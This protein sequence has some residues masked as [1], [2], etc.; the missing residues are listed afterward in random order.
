MQIG[1]TGVTLRGRVTA[2]QGGGA[3]V[4][5]LWHEGCSRQSMRLRTTTTGLA[6]AL[7]L[8]VLP[9]PRVHAAADEQWRSDAALGARMR[10]L[11]DAQAT[12]TRFYVVSALGDMPDTAFVRAR[13]FR[14]PVDFEPA[15]GPYY[16]EQ[17]AQDFSDALGLHLK[18]LVALLR[19]TKEGDAQTGAALKIRWRRD[20]EST[21]AVLGAINPAWSAPAFRELLDVY[22][23]LVDRGVTLRSRGDFAAD[24][25]NFGELHE[26]ALELGDVMA[27]GILSQFPPRWKL[28]TD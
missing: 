10:E 25:G 16:G 6:L 12:W 27:R 4:A 15:V 19:A 20:A 1:S 26:L 17:K 21:A 2:G 28:R 8:A 9:E 5:A 22:L 18:S 14:C 7:L 23:Q 13:L 24:V 11:W 3:T